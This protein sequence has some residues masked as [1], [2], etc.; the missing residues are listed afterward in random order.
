MRAR[1]NDQERGGRLLPLLTVLPGG[2]KD[3]AVCMGRPV[4]AHGF[5]ATVVCEA[6]ATTALHPRLAVTRVTPPRRP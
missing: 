1:V 6:P 5:G 4:C 3:D 2:V